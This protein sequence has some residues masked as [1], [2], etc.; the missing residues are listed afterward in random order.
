MMCNVNCIAH[1]SAL[2]IARIGGWWVLPGKNRGRV[3][4]W[5]F[6]G[7]YEN[8]KGLSGGFSE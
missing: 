3:G 4:V 5:R 1:P 6:S 2:H 8:R 7:S